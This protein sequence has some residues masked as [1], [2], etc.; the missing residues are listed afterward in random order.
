MAFLI[1]VVCGIMP[2]NNR[3]ENGNNFLKKLTKLVQICCGSL[4]P[5]SGPCPHVLCEMHQLSQLSEIAGHILS[6]FCIVF[7]FIVLIVFL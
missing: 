1:C 6:P 7:P 5:F 2:R 4:I 3:R